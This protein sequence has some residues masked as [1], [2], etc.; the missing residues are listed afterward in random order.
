MS[1]TRRTFIKELAVTG[2]AVTA[3]TAM[4]VE[5]GEAASSVNAENNDRCPYFD[6]PMYCKELSKDGKPM[7]EEE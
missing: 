1:R 7:C 4:S 5:N 6:Q 2:A 3:G